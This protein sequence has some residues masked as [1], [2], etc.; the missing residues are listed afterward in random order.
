MEFRTFCS[1]TLEFVEGW[2]WLSSNV[3]PFE[4]A[5]ADMWVDKECL[6]ILKSYGG[7]YVPDVYDGIGNWDYLQ[8]YTAYLACPE[9]LY[10]E[11]GCITPS[12]PI[13]LVEGWNWVS[14]LPGGPISVETALASILDDLNIVK[15]YD[16]FFVPDIYDGIG[17]MVPGKGYKMHVSQECILTYPSS[18]ALAKPIGSKKSAS[19]DDVCSHFGEFETTEDYQ[20]ILIQSIS[21]S[22]IDLEAGDEIGVYTESGLCVGGTVVADNFPLGIMA[23]MDDPRT[24]EVDGSIP[25]EEMVMKYWDASEEKEYDLIITIEDGSELLGESAL[26]RVYLEID[27][28]DLESAAIP[29]IYFLQ[30]NYPNPFNPETRIRYGIPEAGNVKLTLY[31]IDGQLVKQLDSGFKEAG[32]HQVIWDGRNDNGESVS[33]GVYLYRMD[34]EK[35]SDVRKM[36]FL[37]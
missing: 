26:T 22:D 28:S 17:D 19:R 27:L 10:I 35:F 32:Y 7:F 20:A 4:P 34:A 30:Q 24:E 33:S 16:G 8:M 3:P 31:S 5:V 36:V 23:W 2:N 15:S 14:Y 1:I 18:G 12:E 6:E 29:I 37:K 11:G 21:A 9:T 13:A 25:G